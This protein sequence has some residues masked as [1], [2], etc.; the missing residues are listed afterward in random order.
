VEKVAEA[1][2]ADRYHMEDRFAIVFDTK[3]KALDAVPS[4]FVDRSHNEKL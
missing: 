3:P 1:G 2:S 4:K